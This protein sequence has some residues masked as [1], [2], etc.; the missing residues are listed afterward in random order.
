MKFRFTA[1]ALEQ[2]ESRGL[3]RAVVEHVL[4]NPEQVR[5][6]RLGRE[7][8]QSRVHFPD[9]EYLLRVIVDRRT[10]PPDVVTVYRTRYIG[11][12]WRQ[13]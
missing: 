9:G 4:Q 12:Y 11:K 13:E 1:H 5:E 6:E 3:D 10:I 2:L 8:R 7:A